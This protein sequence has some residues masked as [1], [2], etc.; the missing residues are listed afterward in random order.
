M[1]LKYFEKEKASSIKPLTVKKT[2]V[3]SI[4]NN[5]GLSNNHSNNINNTINPK[6]KIT[7]N[8]TLLWKEQERTKTERNTNPFSVKIK[9]ELKKHSNKKLEFTGQKLNQSKVTNS[10]KK[11]NLNSIVI[12]PRGTN[13]KI[14]NEKNNINNNS[15]PTQPSSQ[16]SHSPS[17]DNRNN[18]RFLLHQVSKNLNRTFSKLYEANNRSFSTPN[19]NNA[20]LIKSGSVIFASKKELSNLGYN[21]N[22]RGNSMIKCKSNANFNNNLKNK[23]YENQINIPLIN[24]SPRNE[25][26]TILTEHNN[27]EINQKLNRIRNNAANDVQSL[28][29]KRAFSSY[30]QNTRNNNKIITRSRALTEENENLYFDKNELDL[31]IEYLFILENK[32]KDVLSKLNIYQPCYNECFEW[33]NFYFNSNLY[34]N[35]IKI[36]KDSNNRKIMTYSIKIELLCYCL[37]YTV[38]YD[39]YLNKVIILLKSIFE[40][41]HFNFLVLVRFILHKSKMTY[42][43]YVWYEKLYNIVKNELSMNLTKDDLDEHHIIQ[44]IYHNIK[45]IG[46]YFKIIIDNLYSET[47]HPNIK[48]YKFPF[49]LHGYNDKAKN[50][51]EIISSFFFDAFSFS[52]NYTIEDIDRFFNLFLYKVTDPNASY[53]L[54][55]RVKFPDDENTIFIHNNLNNTSKQN[56]LYFLPKMNTKLYKYTLVLDLD[57]TLIFIKKDTKKKVLILRPYLYEFLERMKFLYE[58]ILFSFG[59]PEY[60]DPIVNIIEKNEKYFEYR[61]YRQHASLNGND[62]V[63]DLNKLGRDLKKIIIVD[64]LPQAF[65]LQK[66]NGICI[67]AFYGDSIGDRDTLKVLSEILERI[68]YNADECNDIRDSLKKESH[69]IISRITSNVDY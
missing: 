49:T 56:P 36:C 30:F 31:I 5:S 42:E 19:N 11:V 2:L 38:S 8:K 20:N 61:L 24:E 18:Y 58:L 33:I 27:Y 32:L 54:S 37:C 1:K 35:L 65:K 15:P 57:E 10:I 34:N 47:Y 69:L 52:D 23:I 51:K 6:T 13:D 3:K 39:K 22:N 68:R 17:K 40:Q 64:N 50:K 16:I 53:I 28:N 25:Y 44:I 60:V 12:S 55:Y 29:H 21:I 14:I 41:I 67:K 46:N 59:T 7:I 48:Q 45:T 66:N 26:K 9:Q 62:Y 4:T 63:K 43:N